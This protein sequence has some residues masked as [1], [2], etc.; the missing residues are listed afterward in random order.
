MYERSL[1]ETERILG[2]H[3]DVVVPVKEVWLE[4][5]KQGQLQRFEV[6]PLMDFTTL[7]ENDE[8]FEFLQA[9]EE[10]GDNYVEPTE[11]DEMEYN[12]D[13]E[14][15]GYYSEDRVRLRYTEVSE[16]P[17]RETTEESDEHAA[18]HEADDG[19][20]KNKITSGAKSKTS[21]RTNGSEQ[22]NQQRPV[23]GRGKV[24]RTQLKQAT[25]VKK[26]VKSRR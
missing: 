5:S 20:S 8:R 6:P 10:F 7:L 18:H 17:E 1:S 9:G 26:K 19:S 14:R 3:K 21:G 23:T 2:T 15:L 25:K 13:I 12:P 22:G 16:D 4:V 24:P 11:E